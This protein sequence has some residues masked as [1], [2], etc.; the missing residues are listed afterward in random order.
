MLSFSKITAAALAASLFAAS[1]AQAATTATGGASATVIGPLSITQTTPLNFG[2]FSSGA[3]S[4]TINSFGSTTGGV[5]SL[6]LGSPAIFNVTGNPNTNF[7]ITG[8]A[9]VVLSSGLNTMTAT[10]TVPTGSSLDTAGNRAFNV[11]GTLAVAANQAT[12]TYTGSYNVSVN[13]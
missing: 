8:P 13:Y 1:A 4:G 6:A 11:I 12:G 9:S 5:T 3:T 7:S 10:L 2:S